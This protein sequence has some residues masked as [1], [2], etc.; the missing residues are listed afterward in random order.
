MAST[1]TVFIT[2]PPPAYSDTMRST[3]L[4][5]RPLLPPPYISPRITQTTE[6]TNNC[7]LYNAIAFITAFNVVITSIA[8]IAAVIGV[9]K[10]FA[11]TF[12]LVIY[13]FSECI[14]RVSYPSKV[15]GSAD[16]I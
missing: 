12:A 6:T 5:D 7:G 11:H 15:S 10:N 4:P 3:G 13:L 9:N 1:E 8:F 2:A 14:G 16:I